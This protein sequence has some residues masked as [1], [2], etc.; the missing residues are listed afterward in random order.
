MASRRRQPAPSYPY[1]SPSKEDISTSKKEFFEKLIEKLQEK[2]TPQP[3]LFY[4]GMNILN[5]MANVE[6]YVK[7]TSISSD[8]G[9]TQILT[10]SLDESIQIQIFAQPDYEANE[11]NYEWLQGTLKRLYGRSDATISSRM[12]LFNVRQQL[13]QT[14]NEF[15]NELRVEAYRC[16]SRDESQDKE[17]FLVKAFIHGLADRKMAAVVKAMKPK[18]LEEAVAHIP[19][20]FRI[21]M[22]KH[23]IDNQLR[24]ISQNSEIKELKTK[25]EELQHQ[26]TQVLQIVKRLQPHYGP[27]NSF[28]AHNR[29]RPT[30]KFNRNETVEAPRYNNT[31]PPQQ[32]LTLEH[33]R[34]GIK[35]FNCS[36]EGHIAR[37][38]PQTRNNQGRPFFRKI[39]DD[40]SESLD[41]NQSVSSSIHVEQTDEETDKCCVLSVTSS[42][43]Q[44]SK[45]RITFY[46]G[47]PDEEL[48]ADQWAKYIHG[49]GRRPKDNSKQILY[50]PTLISE[51]HLEPA[52]NKPVVIGK[53]AGIKSKIFIDSGAEINVID[54]D[55]L[56]ELMT[57]QQASIK[58]IPSNSSIQCANG[59]KM[60]VTGQAIFPLQI[61]NAKVEQRFMVVKKIFPKV[62]VGLRT[63]KTMSI[64][65]D[66]KNDGVI[67]DNKIRVPFISRIIPESV[68]GNE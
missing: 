22:E 54:G 64:V 1:S 37:N 35:C 11:H 34:R 44:N 18:T 57:R 38:C 23:D 55:Y 5:H 47:K 2:E 16:W 10:N 66:A 6:R 68:L 26:L 49:H 63:M 15:A 9:K 3:K 58:F 60:C 48:S 50:Q 4:K 52:R 32:K 53:C 29:P 56:N 17:Y 40:Y 67:V 31:R 59:S 43:K 20:G 7:A 8:K 28:Q 45:P 46:K 21:G 61:G 62:I 41:E 51:S 42:R 30:T 13:D 39:Q 25:I 19:K 12:Q 24:A 33:N 36:K 65:I 27:E 14:V